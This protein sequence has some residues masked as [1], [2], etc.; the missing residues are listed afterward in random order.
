MMVRIPRTYEKTSS[1]IFYLS[2][3][4]AAAAEAYLTVQQLHYNSGSQIVG[5]LGTIK[6]EGREKLYSLSG[7]K[8]ERVL[9]LSHLS[10]TEGMLA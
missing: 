6:G 1:K 9:S 4:A 8:S 7:L 10:V 2:C 3:G 5:R